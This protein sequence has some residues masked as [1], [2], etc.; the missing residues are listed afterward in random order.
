MVR[1]NQTEITEELRNTV[2]E[3]PITIPE[4]VRYKIIHGNY[5]TRD[6]FVWNARNGIGR[7]VCTACG[8]MS[9]V[10]YLKANACSNGFGFDSV[11][12]HD[13]ISGRTLDTGDSFVCPYCKKEVRVKHTSHISGVDGG[14][15][16][17]VEIAMVYNIRGHLALLKYAVCK[18][19]DR[20]GSV[21]YRVNATDGVILVSGK[22]WRVTAIEKIFYNSYY[23]NQWELRKKYSETIGEMGFTSMFFFADIDQTDARNCALEEY[24]KYGR[25]PGAYLRI[26]SR[27]PNI[28]N[29]V[30]GGYQ[31][32]IDDAIKNAV[33][34]QGYYA[35]SEVFTLNPVEKAFCLKKA[36]PHDILGIE[37]N[38]LWTA[39][40]GLHALSMYRNLK[41][42]RGV[43]LDEAALLMMTERVCREKTVKELWG[44]KESRFP[45]IKTLHYLSHQIRYAKKNKHR[46]MPDLQYLQDYWKGLIDVNGGIDDSTM[47]PKDLV[48]AHDRINEQIKHKEDEILNRKIQNRYDEMAALSFEDKEL[49]LLI[50]PARSHE[51]FITEG[52]TLNHC[53]ATY[54]KRH[55]EGNTTICFIRRTAEPDKPFYT[56]EWNG[57]G[58][59]QNRGYKNCA[60]TPEVVLFED[61]WIEYVRGLGKTRSKVK[62]M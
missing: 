46:V 61:R 52:K 53:V 39:S 2:N 40:Y 21:G 14:T 45:V 56:L 15:I 32:L 30:K 48:T 62:V 5:L 28:E 59:V 12:I 51:E 27:Y 58:V 13:I 50:R 17:D 19:T 7:G 10:N 1:K 60:R 16:D 37:K 47:F 18:T 43:K 35:S 22:C 24:M 36:K 42:W 20:E 25:H 9:Q 31:R 11:R 23:R 41:K 55:A 8:Q 54:A 34:L 49:G 6:V 26:W 44:G 4:Y 57:K 29:L 33:T 3:L 38:E